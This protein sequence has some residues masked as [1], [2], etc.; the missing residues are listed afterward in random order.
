MEAIEELRNRL[1]NVLP[2]YL[3]T[4]FNLQRW[5]SA[6]DQVYIQ[7][8]VSLMEKFLPLL[9]ARQSIRGLKPAARKNVSKIC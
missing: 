4:E 7:N 8:M 6:Y 2:Q 9:Q 1:G 3:N 5:I